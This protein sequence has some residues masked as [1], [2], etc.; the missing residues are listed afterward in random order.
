[1]AVTIKWKDNSLL[2]KGHRIYKSSTYFTSDNL[3]APLVDLSPDIEE[4]EDTASNAG[5]NWYI[6]SAYILEYEVFS[7]PFISGLNTAVVNDIF[8]DGSA[9]ATYNFDGD[10]ADLGGNY[11]GTY[12]GSVTYDQGVIGKAINMSDNNSLSTNYSL[13]GNFT[14][15]FWLYYMSRPSG[16]QPVLSQYYDST[17]SQRFII[18]MNSNSIDSNASPDLEI[19]QA[20]NYSG[21][22][23]FV[24]DQY[25][26]I[27]LNHDGTQFTLKN[28][29]SGGESSFSSNG[30]NS[31]TLKL[32]S[33]S[34][35]SYHATD[36][37]YDQLRIFNRVLT[38]TEIDFLYQEGG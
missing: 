5:E 31:G 15:T 6:V 30:M 11:D 28:I 10:T 9:V 14:I 22:V 3:P 4:Y 27:V 23:S 18:R 26:F 13:S 33:Y 34:N 8:D 17:S 37:Y 29:T 12:S 21:N 25:N 32:A 38:Q 16:Y 35:S 19:F 1:M 20:G 24:Y 36:A 7:E 2:E